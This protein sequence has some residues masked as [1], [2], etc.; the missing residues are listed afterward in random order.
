MH[1]TRKIQ[2]CAALLVTAMILLTAASLRLHA[3]TGSC[4]GQSVTLPFTDVAS[5]NVFFCSIAE[6]YFSG[7]TN[8]S[9]ASTYNPSDPVPR[10]QMAAFIT[11]TQDSALK[12]ANRRAAMQQWWTPGDTAVLRPVSLGATPEDISFDG[13]DLWV[14]NQ[15]GSTVSRVRASDGRLMQTWTAAGGA[16]AVI[17]AA[18]KIFVAAFV[19]A[20]L[21]GKIYSINPEA[22]TGG[23][24]TEFDSD[25]GLGPVQIT[26][27]GVN[28]WTVNLGGSSITRVNVGNGVDSTFTGFNSPRDILWDGANLWVANTGESNLKRVDPSNGTVLETITVGSAPTDLIFD[29]T[30][31]WVSNHASNP[32]SISVVR[33]V[34]GLRGTVLATLTGNG[35]AGP[36]GMAFDGERV[37]VCNFN[38]NSVSLFNAADLTPLSNLS[39]GANSQPE[40]AQSDGVN[41]WIVRK[42]L[43]DMVRF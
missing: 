40:S 6:A 41:F 18:G 43:N 34:G 38:N 12:R 30:N 39:T 14:A 10:E 20:N 21:P 22:A 31:I 37:L 16:I 28:L 13:Q 27:D 23:S 8:G 17:A 19:S 7:L 3:D 4:S 42:N 9:T 36:S 11:R 26:F 35:L 15:Q 33:A 2:K 1:Q 25:I 24:V 32:A 5:S 29:G